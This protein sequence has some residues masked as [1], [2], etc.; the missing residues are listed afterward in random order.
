M[1]HDLFYPIP[2]VTV[3]GSLTLGRPRRVFPFPGMFFELQAEKRISPVRG[4]DRG[5]GL[6]EAGFHV[7]KHL[8]AVR[9][10]KPNADQADK[11]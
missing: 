7:E 1:I 6:W 10:D 3:E 2:L 4:D 9:A 11:R 8:C 5:Y